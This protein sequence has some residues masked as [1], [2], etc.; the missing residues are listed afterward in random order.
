MGR[1]RPSV[2]R[3]DREGTDAHPAGPIVSQSYPIAND[4]QNIDPTVLVDDDERVFL[5]WGTFGKLKGVELERDMVTF[6]GA[7]VDA[8]TLTGFFEAPW[9]FKRTGTYYLAYAANTAGPTSEC[10]EAV[11]YACID[12][13]TSPSPLGPWTYRG[14][15]LDPVSSTTS[16]PGI[17]E[18]RGQWYI[19]YHTADAKN[20]G[21]FRRSVA[22]DKLEWDDGAIPSRIKKVIPT[23]GAPFDATPIANIASHARVAASNDP[24][25]VQYWLR[26]VNDGKVRQNPLPP[27][28]WATWSPKNPPQQWI[29]YEWEQAETLNGASLHFWGDHAAGAG[30]GVAAPK[31]WRLEYWDGAGWSAVSAKAP[32]TSVLNANN[33]VDFAPVTTRRLRAVFEAST[34]GVSFAAVALQEWEVFATRAR[35]PRRPAVRPRPQQ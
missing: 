25:P 31:A 13:G 2:R 22:I 12:Y 17:V 27:D 4:I 10:T 5:Y 29:M 32:Y 35:A 1:T 11:Y 23:L 26:A 30:V 18:Y 28:M 6:K 20:G 24:V 8:R 34:D 16:H 21:H 9:L 7:P 19:A 33:R 3:A 15:I 14:V